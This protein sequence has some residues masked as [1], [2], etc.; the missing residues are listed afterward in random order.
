MVVSTLWAAICSSAHGATALTEK[1]NQLSQQ[2]MN[3][4]KT[5]KMQWCEMKGGG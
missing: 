4:G 3:A 5:R 2:V 1:K